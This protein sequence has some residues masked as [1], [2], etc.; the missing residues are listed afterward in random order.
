MYSPCMA[1]TTISLTTEAY[2]ILARL[3]REGQSFSDVIT[4]NLRPK[5]RTCGELLDELERDFEGQTLFN[6]KRLAQVRAG[7]GRRSNRPSGNR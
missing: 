7:R 4:E 6:G 3:K 1:T 2:E 5:P